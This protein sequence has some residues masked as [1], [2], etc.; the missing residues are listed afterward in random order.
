MLARFLQHYSPI[1]NNHHCWNVVLI[2]ICQFRRWSFNCFIDVMCII[3]ET[4]RI[5][6]FFPKRYQILLP[7]ELPIWLGWE[8]CLDNDNQI[9]VSVCLLTIGVMVKN[10]LISKSAKE[11]E[12]EDMWIKNYVSFSL[13][14]KDFMYNFELIDFMIN[15]LYRRNDSF[16][17]AFVFVVVLLADL[18]YILD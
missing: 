13:V 4:L 7:S 18:V 12:I 17:V 8:D 1:S 14:L 3:C 9:N 2:L 16:I 15:D 6:D 11:W 10:T 5:S